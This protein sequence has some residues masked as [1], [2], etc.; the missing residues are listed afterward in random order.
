MRYIN[1]RHTYLQCSAAH[2]TTV[3]GVELLQTQVNTQK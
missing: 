3:N 2:I 1:L